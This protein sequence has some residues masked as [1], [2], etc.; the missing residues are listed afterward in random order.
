MGSDRAVNLF[1]N[2]S[3][4]MSGYATC[5][6]QPSSDVR[7][8]VHKSCADGGS[9]HAFRSGWISAVLLRRVTPR[10]R[11]LYT[12][13]AAK[14]P[15]APPNL[16]PVG[17]ASICAIWFCGHVHRVGSVRCYSERLLHPG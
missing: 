16:Q 15:V 14:P 12:W 8:H 10:A 1:P 11:G 7:D 13:C 6:R 5:S 2:A 9:G 3:Q 4:S 17:I